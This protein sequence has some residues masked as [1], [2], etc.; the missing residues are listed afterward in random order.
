[1]NFQPHGI[2]TSSGAYHE[3]DAVAL[4]TGFDGLTGSLTDLGLHNTEGRSLKEEWK[5]GAKNI[6]GFDA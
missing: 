3:L 5:D 1:M 6:P 4:A 2:V